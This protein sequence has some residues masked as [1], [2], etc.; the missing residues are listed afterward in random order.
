V[1]AQPCISSGKKKKKKG[2]VHSLTADAG[3]K[4]GDKKKE[5]QKK[6][7]QKALEKRSL[8]TIKNKTVKGGKDINPIKTRA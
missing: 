1:S 7:Y 6:T 2:A 8:L 5:K 3:F 4:K